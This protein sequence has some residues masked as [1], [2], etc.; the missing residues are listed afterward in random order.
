MSDDEAESNEGCSKVCS[1]LFSIR[2][3][4]GVLDTGL[5]DDSSF[6]QP[7]KRK[8]DKSRT[9]FGFGVMR[10]DFTN[11][12]SINIKTSEHHKHQVQSS[13]MRRKTFSSALH[14]LL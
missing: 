10:C 12:L 13:K 14:H 8:N 6:F 4:W 11:P 5:A 7:I 1:D 2:S 9:F 3:F